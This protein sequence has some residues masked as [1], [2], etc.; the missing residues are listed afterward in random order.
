MV[1]DNL[2]LKWRSLSADR[3]SLLMMLLICVLYFGGMGWCVVVGIL[4]YH[5]TKLSVS[6]EAIVFAKQV[7]SNYQK[8]EEIEDDTDAPLTYTQIKYALKAQAKVGMLTNTKANR[9]VYETLLLRIFEEHNMRYVDRIK[10]LGPC[11]LACFVHPE[12]YDLSQTYL[13]H[14]VESGNDTIR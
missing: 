1:F 2:V 9:L 11:L 13:N 5:G 4:L 14:Q 6:Q 8:F 7:V 12:S 10:H 3:K